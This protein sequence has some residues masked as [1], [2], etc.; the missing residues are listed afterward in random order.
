MNF[1][2][3]SQL[4]NHGIPDEI[5]TNIRN[6]IQ[7]FFQLPLE[8]KCAYAQ[9]PGE[10]QGYGQSFVVS[11]GQKLDWCDRFSIRAQ[12]PQ[13]RDMKYWPTH[14]HTF[15]SVCLNCKNLIENMYVYTKLDI[16]L[17]ILWGVI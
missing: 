5:I 14:P 9:V 2:V 1:S 4:V 10:L 13:A 16:S 12:P 3:L 7:S 15:R 8:V 17:H 11:E 6:D